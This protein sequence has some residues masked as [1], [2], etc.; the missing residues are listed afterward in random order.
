VASSRTRATCWAIPRGARSERDK[1]EFGIWPTLPRRRPQSQMNANSAAVPAWF[2]VG[3]WLGGEPADV[4]GRSKSHRVLLACGRFSS[5][6]LEC[7]PRRHRPYT[8]PADQSPPSIP[9]YSNDHAVKAR[10]GL[11]AR[12]HCLLCHC[13]EAVQESGEH[14]VRAV[15]PRHQRGNVESSWPRWAVDPDHV[16]GG[17]R[18]RAAIATGWQVNLHYQD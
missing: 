15:P 2:N 13:A 6:G 4:L 5:V 7:G 14:G 16:Q 12:C 17:C 3:R 9:H 8:T 1:G 10:V 11:S 18:V